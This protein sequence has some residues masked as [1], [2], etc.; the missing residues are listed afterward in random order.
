MYLFSVA[1]WPR[2]LI[3]YTFFGNRMP[4]LGLPRFMTYKIFS[5]TDEAAIAA[6]P[7][8]DLNHEIQRCLHGYETGGS[9]Q[10]R[11]AFFE[12]LIWLEK[13]RESKH[14][15]EAKRRRFGR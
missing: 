11:K 7:L 4:F 8:A 9:S 3:R 5:E 12:R 2:E 6:V 1:T 15:I 14:G 13:I 10:G